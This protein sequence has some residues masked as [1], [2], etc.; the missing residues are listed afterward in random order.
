MMNA[1]HSDSTAPAQDLRVRTKQLSLRIIRLNVTLQ[2]SDTVAQILGK[3]VLRSGTSVGAHYHEACR[4]RSVAEF[5]SKIE[6]GTQELEET[7]YWLELLA[8]SKTVS[9]ARL[10]S[11]REECKEL[12]A[13]LTACVKTAKRNSPLGRVSRR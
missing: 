4:A 1:N 8:D 9:D 6:A 11:L 3:Q 5:I 7:I 12:L 10:R 13:I 2:K